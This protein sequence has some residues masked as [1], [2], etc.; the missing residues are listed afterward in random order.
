MF[1]CF[2]FLEIFFFYEIA[3]VTLIY[4]SNASCVLGGYNELS[5]IFITD[6]FS[7]WFGF[8]PAS[9]VGRFLW[10]WIWILLWLRV[11]RTERGSEK[12]KNFKL[13]STNETNQFTTFSITKTSA[14]E[15]LQEEPTTSKRNDYFAFETQSNSNQTKFISKPF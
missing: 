15:L 13:T 6:F 5:L 11:K 7:L 2:F 10:L 8:R 1:A 4:A 12:R 14:A 3:T 9:F